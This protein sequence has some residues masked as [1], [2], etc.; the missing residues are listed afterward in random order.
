MTVYVCSSSSCR[1]Q[2]SARKA[3]LST[4]SSHEAERVGC[5]KLCKGPVLGC[6]VDG[7]IEWFERLDSKKALRALGRLLSGEGL[8][9]VLQKRRSK[10][11][12]GKLR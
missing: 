9:K 12:A 6:E 11:R 7:Q 4:I 1:K 10:K 8:P 2:K 5:Q 3:L